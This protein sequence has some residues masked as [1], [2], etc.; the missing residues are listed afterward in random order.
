MDYLRQLWESANSANPS[1]FKE[2]TPL[3]GMG[4]L[5]GMLIL[6]GGSIVVG[7]LFYLIIPRL[8]AIWNRRDEEFL[9]Q[10]EGKYPRD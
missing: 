5:E 6:V 2:N 3:Y 8:E 4:L 1:P 10:M 9:R 7:L